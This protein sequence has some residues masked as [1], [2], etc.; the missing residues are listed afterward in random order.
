MID[1]LIEQINETRQ[2]LQRLEAEVDSLVEVSNTPGEAGAKIRQRRKELEIKIL[3]TSNSLDSFQQQ[4]REE[5]RM[6]V[7]QNHMRLEGKSKIV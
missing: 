2:E 5:Q 1:K 6:A 4:L 3:K 7:E